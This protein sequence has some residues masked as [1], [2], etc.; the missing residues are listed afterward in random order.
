[1]YSDAKAHTE[2]VKRSRLLQMFFPSD[3]CD[4]SW[5]STRDGLIGSAF[6]ASI[7]AYIFAAAA[8]FVHVHYHKGEKCLFSIKW[9]Q[10]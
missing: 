4:P 3:A 7:V 5:R 2:V 9:E 1:M 10:I 6:A 8:V